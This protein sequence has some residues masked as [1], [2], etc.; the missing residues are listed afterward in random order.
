MILDTKNQIR[1][2]KDVKSVLQSNKNR[3]SYICVHI[4]NI[5]KHKDI[6]DAEY[7]HQWIDNLLGG[8]GTYNSWMYRHHKNIIKNMSNR[9]LINAR[10]HWIDWMIRQLESKV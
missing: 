9:D 1:L 8:S 2:L 4:S 6:K 7:L 10:I 5:S 3:Y